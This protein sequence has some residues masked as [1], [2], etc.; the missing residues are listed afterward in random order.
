M[1]YYVSLDPDPK[2]APIVVDVVELPSGA[3]SISVDGKPADVD[4]LPL[5]D[6][7]QLSVRVDGHIVDLTVE[8]SP[9]DLGAVA[10]GHRSYVR[11]ESERMRSAEQAKRARGGD[12]EKIVKSPMPGRVVKVLVQKGDAVQP[13]QALVVVEAMKMENEVRAKAA[14]TIAELHVKAGE[15][16]EGNA[17]L[18]TLA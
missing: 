7:E 9:P 18:I 2:A 17:K 10:S 15:A 12:A 13:G 11:V 14:A 1:R 4:V 8:G 5:R 3:L 16:V 6:H